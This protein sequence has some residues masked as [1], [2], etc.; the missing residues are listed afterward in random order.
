MVEM[1]NGDKLLMLNYAS[2]LT[3][4]CEAN[5]S[6][7]TGILK[8][9]YTGLNRN[10]SS[11]SKEVFERCKTTMYNCPIVCNYNRES[12]SLG[13]HDVDIVCDD[14]GSIRLVNITHPIGVIPEGAK[15]WWEEVEEDNGDKH[16]YLFT[17]VLLWKRQEAYRKIK[18]DG[19]V[20]HSME[21]KVKDSEM[22]DN[23]LY[24]KDFEFNAFCLIGC[25]PCFEGASLKTF[26]ATGIKEQFATMMQELKESFSLVNTSSEVDNIKN[27]K[28]SMKGGE[29]ILNKESNFAEVETPVEGEEKDFSEQ[30][31]TE[32]NKETVEAVEG[33]EGNTDTT[34]SEGTGEES[35]FE[36][37][38]TVTEEL[39]RALKSVK[40]QRDW[41]ECYRY[42]YVDCDLENSKVYCWDGEDWLLYGFDYS[43]NGDAVVIDFDSKKRMKYVIVEFNEGEVQESPFV[44]TYKSIAEKASEAKEFEKKFQEES[45][46][47]EAMSSELQ[48]LRAYKKDVEAAKESADRNAVFNKFED[49][50]GIE[51]F[52][53][54][55]ANCGDIDIETLEEKCYAIRGKFGTV[56]KFSTEVKAPKLMVDKSNAKNETKEPYGGL[57]LE[58][59]KK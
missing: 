13:G 49:L 47:A 27:S 51:A 52:E 9:A 40:I 3:D 56:A 39:V 46:V 38:S 10:H 48:T 2:S 59:G 25:E 33:Q 17:E 11:I 19:I 5:S 16:E 15:T 22:V 20:S 44:E 42:F 1:N 23:T 34:V 4:L 30:E 53:N 43:L 37:T 35:S 50:I 12:D 29:G 8:I 21:I 57:F 28:C 36:L 31:F 26:S 18:K 32:A 58:Y 45:A 55:K 7:D 14:D 24:I 54:L 6:F 41:G